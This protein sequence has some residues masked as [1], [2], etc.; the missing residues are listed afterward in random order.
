MTAEDMAMFDARRAAANELAAAQIRK[1]EAENAEYVAG[2]YQEVSE[3]F[4]TEEQRK[5]AAVK[6]TYAETRK[7]LQK[8]LE[9]GNLTQQQYD[10]LLLQNNKAEAQEIKDAWLEMYGDYYQQREAL[11]RQ[12]EA[13]LANIPAE[14]Q[15]QARKKMVEEMSALDSD[16][17]KNLIDWDSVFGD[18]DNQSI[19]SL[20][21]NLDRIRAYFEQNKES[22]SATE[23]KDYT[24]AIKRMED[25]IADRNPFEAMHKSLNDI[26]AAKTEL[27]NALNE[28]ADAQRVLTDA[29]TEYNA[30]QEYLNQLQAEVMN[31]DLAEDS[32]AMVEAKKRMAEAEN[33]LNQA[34]ERGVKAE[35]NVIKG[36]NNLTASYRNF[37]TALKNCGSV[38]GDV[39]T[40]AKNL[41]AVFSK[42]LA[43]SMEKGID[44]MDEIID[45][46]SNVINAISDVGK[47]AAT[48]IEAAVTA[49]AQGST[50]AAAAGATAISTIEKASVILAVISAALQVATAIASLFNSDDAK[51]KQIESLQK[52]IDQLQW[53]LNN[54]DIVRFN[55]E[56][57]DA[58]EQV[59]DTLAESVEYARQ[60]SMAYQ[61][62]ADEAA[63]AWQRYYQ[64]Q[65]E[66]Q[67]SSLALDAMIAEKKAKS[68]LQ[69]EAER[70]ATV[71]LADAW[72]NVDY[73]TGRALGEA[74]YEN[75]RKMIEN[76]AEQ[77]VLVQEQLEAEKDKKNPDDEAIQDYENQLKELQMDGV[78]VVHDMLE[79]II[80][81]SAADLA[82]QLGDAFIEA[83]AQ[84][85]DAMEAWH[86]KVNDIVADVMK[87]MLVQKLLEEPIGKLFGE[88]Q[89][90][91]FTDGKFNGIQAVIDSSQEFAD[92]LNQIGTDFQSIWEN[93]PDDV[94]QW[95]GMDEREGSQRGI[96]TASQDSVDENNARLTTIQGHTYSLVQGMDE[97]NGTASLILD[98]VTGIERNTDEANNKLDNMGNRVRNIENTIDD[99][100]RNGIRIRG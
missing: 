59:R 76:I 82:S 65:R 17:F 62:A 93:L 29:Q 19:Q 61:Q 24:E 15:A 96:A 27:V 53:E 89:K 44:F 3:V 56:Y 8:D 50:A 32:E 9:A 47:G 94:K 64:A 28:V 77:A 100:Q 31:G 58:V 85:E 78:N 41:A 51:N 54:Q 84:G 75:A 74:R 98:R 95:F 37:A 52:R 80:G 6:K 68:I 25:E 99:I 45:A 42:D 57:K 87:R 34:K 66:G 4:M 35:N 26:G 33:K 49:S 7:Q 38:V 10:D 16:R 72:S 23:I 60:N 14:Y 71:K 90:K 73:A 20:R 88:M 46:A 5:I 40:K 13:N 48:G 81:S 69:S 30:A 36:R 91:W 86:K 2:L 79:E 22:M 67:N 63:A 55:E 39:G 97:L 21:A 18:L 43:D 92:G 1:T 83:A 11:A 70:L 12:W